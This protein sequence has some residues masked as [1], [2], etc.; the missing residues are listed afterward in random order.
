MFH[1]VVLKTQKYSLC[2][3]P[4]A[5]PT[6]ELPG[7]MAIRLKS[8]CHLTGQ[9]CNASA[10]APST[11]EMQPCRAAGPAA[12]GRVAA[13]LPGAAAAPLGRSGVNLKAR[14]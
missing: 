10:G 13:C 12:S 1:F 14:N 5:V 3:Q 7:W 6:S 2:L 9:V 4:M 8:Q 11:P